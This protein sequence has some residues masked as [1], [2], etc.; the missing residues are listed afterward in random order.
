MRFFIESRC[1]YNKPWLSDPMS[2]GPLQSISTLH[3]EQGL[4]GK[5]TD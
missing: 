3:A 1:T 4:A 5:T 2:L